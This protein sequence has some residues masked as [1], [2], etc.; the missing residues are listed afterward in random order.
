MSCD[1]RSL[2]RT[3]C[4]VLCLLLH[5]GCYEIPPKI[6]PGYVGGPTAPGWP[7]PAVYHDDPFHPA[8]LLHH[9]LF[10]LGTGAAGGEDDGDGMPS[11]ESALDA[12]DRAEVIVLA[13]MVGATHRPG[14]GET[15]AADALCPDGLLRLRRDTAKAVARLEASPAAGDRHVARSLRHLLGELPESP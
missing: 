12:V 13:R 14:D 7:P 5:G 15:P 9:R 8:N 10:V 11:T 4:G 6:P 1:A 3:V 2:V